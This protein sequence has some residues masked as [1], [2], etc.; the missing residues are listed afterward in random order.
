M[1]SCRIMCFTNLGQNMLSLLKKYVA[2]ILNMHTDM[3]KRTTQGPKIT[4]HVHLAIL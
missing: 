4:K 3:D 1:T 2:A